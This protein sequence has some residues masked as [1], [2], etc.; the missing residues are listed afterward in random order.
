LELAGLREEV[1]FVSA[2]H[3]LSERTACKLLGVERSSYRYEPRP[4]RN[5]ELREE[6][7]KLARQKPRYGYRRLHVL[8]VRRGHEVNVKRVYRLYLEEGLSVRRKK[9]RRLVRDRACEPRLVRANQEWAMD[10]IVDGLATGRMVRILSVMDA[11]TRECLALEADFSLGS[12]RVT[13]VLERLIEERGRPESLRSDNGP[14]FTSRRMLG[15]SEDWK[16]GL[17]HIQPGRPMQNGHVESFHG[18]LRDE[19]LNAS[20]FRTL[21]DVRT[22]VASWRREYNCERPHSSLGYK[23]PEEF[24]LAMGYG[25]VESKQRFPHPHSPDDDDE[26]NLVPKQNRETP[27]MAG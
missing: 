25:D 6:L 8:L 2:E 26:I 11:Y 19:C 7:L 12:G 4:D 10:F 20:W 27:V 21:N 23:T 22:T 24:R 17:V 3:G 16:V 5:A 15:W 18:R 14:E 13:R 1:A 9:R